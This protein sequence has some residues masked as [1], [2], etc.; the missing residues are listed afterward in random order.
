MKFTETKLNGA[1]I[2]EPLKFEDERGFFATSWSQ[3][4]FRERGLNPACV[5][6]NISYNH[7]KGALRGLHYQAPPHAQA[8]FIRCTRGAIYDVTID[9]SPGS[10][11]FKQW[12]GVELTQDNYKM[13][14]VPEGFAHG[15]QAL[16]DHTE[17]FYQM[18]SGYQPGSEGGVRWNDPAFSI[19]WPLPVTSISPKDAHFPDFV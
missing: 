4:E 6:C 19:Q 14:F 5:Q 1:C 8:K 11:T 9:L 2:V 10:P 18:S 12:L 13:L 17:I 15:Y 16:A 7:H 3:S